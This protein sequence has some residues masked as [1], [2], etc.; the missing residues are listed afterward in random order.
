MRKLY[1]GACVAVI[2]LFSCFSF[3]NTNAQHWLTQMESSMRNLNYDMSFVVLNGKNAE[4]YRL[5]H[6]QQNGVE[7]ELLTQLNGPGYEVVRR[8]DTISHFETGQSPYSQHGDNIIG[9]IPDVLFK[10]LAAL[11]QNYQLVVGGQERIANRD[12]QIVRL[13]A[14]D[15]NKYNYW[16]WLDAESGILMRAA[17]VNQAG[18]KVEQ[19]QVV[20]LAVQ[21]ELN[22]ALQELATAKLPEVVA[23]APAE[24]AG[25]WQISWIPEG[26]S[27]KT[28]DRRQLTAN[29]E[30]ADYFLYSDGLVNVSVFVQRPLVGGSSGYVQSGAT[31][32]YTHKAN[33]FDVSVVGKVPVATAKRMAESVQ[34]PL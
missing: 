7:L 24:A 33:G 2:A 11:T 14:F 12:A 22:P 10:P 32:L 20:S 28:S 6:G 5:L 3:A 4:P 31:S 19:L 13:V 8:G 30:M 26:F 34:R 1:R 9:P 25:S 15:Q 18:E 23:P 21:Q 17:Y 27:L 29:K 16:L